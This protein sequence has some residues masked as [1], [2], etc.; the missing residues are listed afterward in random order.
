MV[1]GTVRRTAGRWGDVVRVRA[2]R[3][4][5]RLN[6]TGDYARKNPEA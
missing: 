2:V 4:L 5:K 3:N 1:N 6:E